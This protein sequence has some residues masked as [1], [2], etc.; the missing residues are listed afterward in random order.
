MKEDGLTQIVREVQKD[1][2]Q[3][4]L[5]YSQIINKVYFWCYT[6]VGNKADADDATQEAMIRIYQKLDTL[7]D[8]RTFNAWM[9]RLVTNA[10]YNH[11]R[12]RKRKD[13]EFP[14]DSEF[15]ESFES[16]LKEERRDSI[17]QEQY[18]LDETKE[19]IKGFIGNLSKRQRE[20]VT[21]YYLEEFNMREVAAIL[22]CS[23]GAI[24][25]Q[26]H[27]S[28]K[29]LEEQIS[30]Y[31]DKN[32]IK[33]YNLAFIPLLV[34]IL[35]KLRE[36]LCQNNDFTYDKNLYESQGLSWWERLLNFVSNH[37]IATM[38]TTFLC[39]VIIIGAI[40]LLQGAD[41]KQNH[42]SIDTNTNVNEDIAKKIK[43]YEY[44]AAI[45]YP[46]FPKKDAV[47]VRLELQ[48]E[49]TIHDVSI[50]LDDKELPFTLNDKELPFTLNDKELIVSVKQNGK[51]I[52]NVKNEE[53]SLNIK[54][55]DK[56]APELIEVYY[57]KD[58]LELNI[59]NDSK[60]NYDKSYV[61]YLGENY[62]ITDQSIVNGTFK[63]SVYIVLFTM[64]DN[65]IKYEI[66]TK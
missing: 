53:I 39:T 41:D 36:E 20:I 9:Y 7:N 40:W 44:I 38:A 65:Y 24:K 50:T 66:N 43:G 47:D 60:I 31:Q 8:V 54:N 52:I 30:A 48:E 21:L 35:Q 19:L 62:K 14:E 12:T 4:E 16:R 29:K 27:H 58:Y 59:D 55:I 10:C 1:K 34:L 32:D 56:D 6:I 49:V 22:D 5:L 63:G 64:D 46:Q 26:L 11:L 18:N 37:V 45:Y 13:Y 25:V 3:F 61:E 15:S 33:L 17:P 57:Y 2:G 42:P 28:R 23:V 51:L